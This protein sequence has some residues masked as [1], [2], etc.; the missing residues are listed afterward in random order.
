MH[1]RAI[2]DRGRDAATISRAHDASPLPKLFAEAL[3]MRVC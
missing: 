3:P 2:A 1:K